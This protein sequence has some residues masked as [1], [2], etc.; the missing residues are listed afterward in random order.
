MYA[1]NQNTFN[2]DT[3]IYKTNYFCL[4]NTANLSFKWEFY[5]W[6]VLKCHPPSG[7]FFARNRSLLPAWHLERIQISTPTLLAVP[8]VYHLVISLLAKE[9]SPRYGTH[10][11]H[12]RK[13]SLQYACHSLQGTRMQ[14]LPRS[15]QTAPWETTARSQIC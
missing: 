13:S 11:N 5:A 8:P 3:N 4:L 9:V 6:C 1:E 14:Y 15:L 2:A 10:C 7:N 12:N